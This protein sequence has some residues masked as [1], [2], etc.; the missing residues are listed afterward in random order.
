MASQA[1]SDADYEPAGKTAYLPVKS[2]TGKK[3]RRLS[4]KER[5]VKPL[6][7]KFS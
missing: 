4:Q 5:P 6:R 7:L 1:M 2:K 3:Q